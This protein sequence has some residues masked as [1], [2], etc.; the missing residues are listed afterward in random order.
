MFNCETETDVS[1]NYDYD[2]DDININS[3]DSKKF[4]KKVLL[5][6]RNV[7]A[8]K[9]RDMKK[10]FNVSVF[11]EICCQ[12]NF[13]YKRYVKGF[14]KYFFGPNGIVTEKVKELRDYYELKNLKIGLNKKIY[15]GNLDFYNFMTKMDSYTKRL[16][17]SKQKILSISHN[18]DIVSSF[19]AAT[20]EIT[21]KNKLYNPNKDFVKINIQKIKNYC[22]SY[23]NS[24]YEENMKKNFSKT[25]TLTE[26]KT[27]FNHSINQRKK[28][29]EENKIQNRVKQKSLKYKVN[30]STRTSISLNIKKMKMNLSP[31]KKKIISNYN[32]LSQPKDNYTVSSFNR[33]KFLNN[34]I[35]LPALNKKITSDNYNS[36]H[37]KTVNKMLNEMNNAINSKI[38]VMDNSNILKTD[39]LFKVKKN[40]K[41][42]KSI[43]NKITDLLDKNNINS[44]KEM[45]KAIVD[46]KN[47]RKKTFKEELKELEKIRPIKASSGILNNDKYKN[48]N[49]ENVLRDYTSLD[50][51]VFSE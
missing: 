30:N 31:Q 49:L 10:Y 38:N 7:M 28:F 21:E 13:T 23:P 24:D 2:L 8:E 50:N 12:S 51:F 39:I 27:N 22:T 44:L 4:K 37:E 47:K 43:K 17:H 48:T 16:F 40:K 19:E 35:K 32:C 14:G 5:N 1:K 3:K 29:P 46:K 26:N 18:F 9:N 25:A 11:R 34:K 33:Y 20:K 45:K 42:N 36:N 6:I 15:A 41:C